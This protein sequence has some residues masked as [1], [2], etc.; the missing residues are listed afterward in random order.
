MGLFLQH[1]YL[2]L[3]GGLTTKPWPVGPLRGHSGE[4]LTNRKLHKGLV[5]FG[6]HVEEQIQDLELP[7]VL[8]V[9]GIVGKVGQVRQYLLLG[10]CNR[11]ASRC[12]RKHA[13][14]EE[15]GR[16]AVPG[17]YLGCPSPGTR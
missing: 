11:E 12:V 2:P 9:F 13:Q 6:E 8:V 16:A 14:R 4:V 1:N 10:L 17:V 5:V 7:E 15:H 3:G